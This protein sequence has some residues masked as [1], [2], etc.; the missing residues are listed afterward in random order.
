MEAF[1]LVST[2]GTGKDA[3]LPVAFAA[4]EEG[5]V[6]STCSICISA[7]AAD[8][9][10]ARAAAAQFISP[11]SQA[12]IAEHLQWAPVSLKASIPEAIARQ[13]PR[14]DQLIK[15]DMT[16]MT[17]QRSAWTERFNREIAR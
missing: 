4:P 5:S 6:A 1:R 3:G 16:T 15:L 13:L 10:L 8:L 14:P 12:G 11:E 2:Y 9:D 7:K 17:Q